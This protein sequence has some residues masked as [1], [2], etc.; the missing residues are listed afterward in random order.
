MAGFAVSG[1]FIAPPPLALHQIPADPLGDHVTQSFHD[2]LRVTHFEGG[3]V[4]GA[5]G[6]F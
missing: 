1:S 4:G 5:A 2:L 3:G 6:D